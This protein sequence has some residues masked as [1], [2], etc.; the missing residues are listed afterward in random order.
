MADNFSYTLFSIRIFDMSGSS[1]ILYIVALLAVLLVFV[2][3]MARWLGHTAVGKIVT[4]STGLLV[5]GSVVAELTRSE[6]EGPLPQVS[7]SSP[8]QQLP[9]IIILSADGLDSRRMSA[10]GY[11]R[12][13]TPFLSSILHKGLVF[14][15]AFTNAANTTGSIAA[16]LTG[17]LPTT[18]RVNF[19]PDLFREKDAY[20]HLPGILR[21]IG[22]HNV[23]ITVRYYADSG[24]LNLRD[25]FHWA[26]G[27]SLESLVPIE[28]PANFVRR[29]TY[30]T[31]FLQQVQYRASQRLSHIFGRE[32]AS[33]PFEEVT[34]IKRVY[35]DSDRLATL[36]DTIESAQEPFFINTHFMVTHGGTFPNFTRQFSINQEQTEKWMRDFYDDSLI[37]VDLYLNFLFDFLA[38]KGK[39]ER[40][41]IILTSDHG[42]RSKTNGGEQ[43]LP[44][45]FFFPGGEL[46]GIR[47]ANAQRIDVAPTLLEYLG[48][49]IPSWME[50]ASLLGDN[51]SPTRLIIGTTTGAGMQVGPF[52]EIPDVKPPLY[53]LAGVS[54]AQ[55]QRFWALYLISGRFTSEVNSSHTAPCKSE[56]L[57]E[58]TAAKRYLLDH[59]IERDY[60][61][62]ALQPAASNDPPVPL[63]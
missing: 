31:F 48:Q 56:E 13:T 27:R 10:F 55:C 33:S 21:M 43:R 38:E 29:W 58:D 52:F 1:R 44:L 17:R 40:T 45:V 51:L 62:S 36:S 7:V 47:T 16:M 22:Y 12:P 3:L 23:E 25:A 15:N 60:P 42:E 8:E 18:T 41:L 59:L 49:P 54:L 2:S 50:G 20:Q 5:L 19:R 28:V 34:S 14:E 39:L 57:L 4:L 37:D 26:N 61:L 32:P 53:T 46:A 24:D 35:S 63:P 9:N 30:E 6:I 11:P